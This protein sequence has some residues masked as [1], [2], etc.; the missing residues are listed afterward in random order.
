MKKQVNQENIADYQAVK[1][2]SIKAP[3]ISP[4]RAWLPGCRAWEIG[5]VAM[6]TARCMHI[7]SHEIMKVQGSLKHRQGSSEMMK[8]R[9]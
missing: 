6:S 2:K 4:Q 8:C 7:G 1:L 3:W 9:M 5:Q